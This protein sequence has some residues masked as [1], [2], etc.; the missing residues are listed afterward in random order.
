MDTTSRHR[1]LYCSGHLESEAKL[2]RVSRATT[3]S[4]GVSSWTLSVLLP[5]SSNEVVVQI[6]YDRH[7]SRQEPNR[8]HWPKRAINTREWT[9]AIHQL[10]PTARSVT[11]CAFSFL[12]RSNKLT[13]QRNETNLEKAPR[14]L[15]LREPV[16]ESE[17]TFGIWGNYREEPGFLS[18]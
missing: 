14:F 18:P 3:A 15:R 2:C 8:L 6:S 12:P 5:G 16:S 13:L 17:R 11:G 10:K 7:Y 4:A 1:V 9:R